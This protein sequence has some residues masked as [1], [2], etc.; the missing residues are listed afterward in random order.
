ML[1]QLVFAVLTLGCFGLFGRNLARIRRWI[2]IGEGPEATR[3]DHPRERLADMLQFA[4][5][6]P[7]MFRDPV[8]GIMH[9]MIFWGFLL[10][11]LG[12]LETL[13]RG[14]VGRAFDMSA[15]LGSGGLHDF[16]LSSQDM[17]NFVVLA[18]VTFAILRRIFWAPER[19]KSVERGAKVDA[20]VV[21][22]FIWVLVATA[23]LSMGAEVRA[24]AL[25]TAT[26][27]MSERLASGLGV[28]LG[29]QSPGAWDVAARSV[30]WLHCVTLFSFVTF[31]PYS[32]H[33]HLVAAFPNIFLRQRRPRGYLKPWPIDENAE[34]FGAGKTEA[35]SW[36]SL[37]DGFSCVE[38]GRCQE[39]CPAYATGKPLDP[40]KIATAMRKATLDAV[41]H[42]DPAGGDRKALIGGLISEEELWAC[43]TC[44]A[45]MEA[46]PIYIEHIPPIVDMRRFLSM[47]EGRFPDELQTTFK[48]METHGAPWAFPPEQRMDWAQGLDVTTMEQKPDVEYL[49][50]VGCA[51][52]FDARYKKVTQSIAKILKHADVSFSVLGKEERC[53]GD[54][55][56]RLGNEY[57][58]QTMI[59]ENVGNFQRYKVKKIV[60]GCPH[61]L[62]SLKN[63]YPDYGLDGVEV[64]HHTQLIAELQAQGRLPGAGDAP[65]VSSAEA[66]RVTFH[67]SCYLGRHNGEYEAPRKALMGTSRDVALVEMKRSRE[68]GFCC[69][70]GGG[71]MWMEEKTGQRINENRAAEALATGA[72]TVAT[73][74]PF[75]MTMMTDGVK[76]LGKGSDVAVRDVAEIVAD[77]LTAENVSR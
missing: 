51:G 2:A 69:G 77:E 73:A 53:T 11:S 76:G 10:V 18:A 42:P 20:M 33:F 12:T 26:L 27:V 28:L 61:C 25:P 23:L 6:Q 60:T 16:Y 71:R 34:S 5:L 46:C 38:C 57:L 63:E 15:I 68:T 58:A 55:A 24:G 44:G 39:Q 74:C 13:I 43:T 72:P 50:W 30:W 52:A 32:K 14:V 62:N 1:E 37:L 48:N 21:L 59:Q 49:F 75:C 8:A 19:L 67:D 45:C 22:G 7:K 64:V 40:R 41:A 66:A 29:L 36:K 65:R 35:L 17:G 70:A 54:S 47:T 4:F 3:L 56:R 9:A 31:L